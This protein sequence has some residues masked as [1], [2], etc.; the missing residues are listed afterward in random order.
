MIQDQIQED[1]SELSL[2]HPLMLIEMGTGMGKGLS[3]IKCISKSRS[4]KKWLILVPQIAHIENMK[5]EFIKF[6]YE[7]LLETKIEG[8]IC[9]ASFK[10]YKGSVVNLA[11][12]EVQHL[13]EERFEALLT[14]D[15]DQIVADSATVPFDVR[16]RL[17]SLG[18]FYTYRKTLEEGIELG[19]LPEPE[20]HLVGIKLNNTEKIY[21]YTYKKGKT[22][23]V[24]ALGY[25][26]KISNSIVFWQDKYKRERKEWQ[27]FKFLRLANERKRFLSEQKTDKAIEIIDQFKRENSRFI[28]FCGSV[29]QSNTLGGD[30]AVNFEKQKDNMTV[31]QD[32]NKKLTSEIYACGMLREGLTLTGLNRGLLIQLDRGDTSENLREIQALGRMMRETNPK[33]YVLYVKGTIDQTVYLQNFKDNIGIKYIK[34]EGG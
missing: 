25:Y 14:I 2:S 20:I 28:V 11:L 27:M 15:Y 6:G 30:L 32:F 9:Y 13:S 31:I 1:I 4:H 5:G 17:E 12:N 24:T 7:D 26:A 18:G 34:E 29:E 23:K 33:F 19:I 3:L 22:I 10:N 8:I 21:E 16:E